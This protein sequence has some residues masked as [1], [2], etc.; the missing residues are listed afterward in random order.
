MLNPAR[1]GGQHENEATHK[2]LERAGVSVLDS[3]PAFDDTHEKSM[4]VDD[5]I[6][7]VKSLN[8]ETKNL[9]ETRNYAS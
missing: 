4:L 6:A 9:T 3:N 7:L 2:K 8:W 5:E 1:R